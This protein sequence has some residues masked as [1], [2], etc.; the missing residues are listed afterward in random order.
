M[1]KSREETA[2]TRKRIVASSSRAFRENGIDGTGL[3]ELM[4]AAGLETQGGFYKHFASKG[5]LVTEAMQA[6]LDELIAGVE[7]RTAEA[8]PGAAIDVL[9]KGYLSK[10]HREQVA[11][12]CP[13]AALGTELRRAD[14]ETSQ[15]ATD[16]LKR[17]VRAVAKQVD[18]KRVDAGSRREAQKRAIGVVS[19]MVGGLMLSRIAN[20][21]S[22][23]DAFLRETREFILQHHR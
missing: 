10:R 12:G 20:D 8:E 15:V 16:G 14:E 7:R 6:S 1:R 23:A 11:D 17:L 19:A 9:V 21:A 4:Q 3:S 13:L 18:A 2:E 22:L 5:Q